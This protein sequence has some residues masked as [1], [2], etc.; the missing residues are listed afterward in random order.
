MTPTPPNAGVVT[1]PTED[2]AYRFYCDLRDAV[3]TRRR[4]VPIIRYFIAF[5]Y[6]AP[7]PECTIVHSEDPT[8]PDYMAV[9][10]VNPRPMEKCG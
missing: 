2:L 1:E 7:K 4:L 8:T 10:T 5:L 3:H 9:G 6:A